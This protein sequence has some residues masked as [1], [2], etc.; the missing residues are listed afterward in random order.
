MLHRTIII[1][2]SLLLFALNVYSLDFSY[3]EEINWQDVQT[4]NLSDEDSFSRCSFDGASYT[5]F[6]PIPYFSKN[7]LIHT[8]QANINVRIE[9]AVYISADSLETLLLVDNFKPNREINIESSIVVSRKQ[10]YVNVYLAPL[11]WNEEKNIVEKLQSFT[12]IIDLEERAL[13]A[14]NFIDYADNSVLDKGDWFKIKVNKGGVYKLTYSQLQE[15]GFNVGGDVSKIAIYGN[16][17]GILPEI[18]TDF[19]FDD[20]EE[21]AIE[22]IGDNDGSFDAGDYILF[23]GDDPVTWKYNYAKYSFVHQNNYYDDYTYYFITLKSEGAGKRIVAISPIQGTASVDVTDF[24]DYS[25]HELDK[26]NL[27]GT[28]RLWLGEVFD[29]SQN[30]K[31]TFSFNFPN[32]IKEPGAKFFGA[33]ASKAYSQNKFLIYIN[34]VFLKTLLMQN[35]SS[36][37]Y[38][39]GKEGKTEFNFT[40][41][42]DVLNVMIEFQRVS[43]S[44]SGYLNYIELNVRRQLQFTGNQ[45]HFRKVFDWNVNEIAK[46]Y[47]GGQTGNV[48]IW[49]ISNVTNVTEQ[50]TSVIGSNTTFTST[51]DTL[52]QYIVFNGAEFYTPEFVE[53]VKNQNLHAIKNINY[54]IITYPGFLEE[55][56]NLANF[57]R[58]DKNFKVYVT[59][60]QIIYNEFS[61]GSQDITAI[62]DFVKM[63]YDRSDAGQEIQYLLLFGDAS[64]DYKNFLP[65]DNNLVPCW[66]HTSSLNIVSSIATDDYYGYLDDGEG[67]IDDR[68]RVDIGIGRFVVLTVEEAQMAVDKTISYCTN[69]QQNMGTWR[70]QITFVADDEDSN[71]HLHDA[72]ILSSIIDEEQTEYIIDKI[73]L[74]AYPQISTPSG[75]RAPEVNKAINSKI[76]KGT[77]IFNYSGHGGE[78]GLSHEGI[79]E[80]PDIKSWNNYNKLPIFITATCEFSRYDDPNRISAGEEV[81]LN[82]NGGAIALFTTARATYASSNLALNKAIYE[83]NLFEKV[84]GEY[85]R[86]GDVIR[87]SKKL[88]NDNDKKFILIGDPAV[89]LA[90]PENNTKTIKINSNIIIENN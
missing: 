43:S 28:G 79:L 40:P 78:S 77:L 38:E 10:P 14:N 29:F 42:N 2:T 20:L 12:I 56:N 90:Y 1:L 4:V 7:Y 81:F 49:D 83:N 34:D 37:G 52:R 36:S 51:T 71:R 67:H 55:A 13:F 75:Q 62:R 73:Y 25:L 74:D 50:T 3:E 45:M 27:A 5:D 64:Y 72:E 82:A 57:H 60:P 33:F 69:T 11:R 46:Y 58:N 35:T 59:T 88:S 30:L 80:I 47:V 61:S 76:E 53:K 9:N 15:M 63:L 87:K 68:N 41:K 66:E 86:F 65:I 23:Y 44:S 8:S 19:R 16:G 89:R 24:N 84:N 6:E 22:I 70:N 85:P 26:I 54:L 48:R 21:N 31:Q 32:I 18:N 39:Y 17:G